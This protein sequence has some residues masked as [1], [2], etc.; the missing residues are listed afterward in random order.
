MP[1]SSGL[2]NLLEYLVQEELLSNS[3]QNWRETRTQNGFF[4]PLFTCGMV[5]GMFGLEVLA[6]KCEPGMEARVFGKIQGGID[7][8]AS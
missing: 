4:R 5:D 7:A 3:Q 2:V 6:V 1:F 8:V